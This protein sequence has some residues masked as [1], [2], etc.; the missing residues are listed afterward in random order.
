MIIVHEQT[1]DNVG[2]VR[3]LQCGPF[4]QTPSSHGGGTFFI[5]F[6]L[7]I[8]AYTHTF[9]SRCCFES[10]TRT[11]TGGF[12]HDR[13]PAKGLQDKSKHLLNFTGG[14]RLA[15]SFNA[16]VAVTAVPHVLVIDRLMYNL[17]GAENKHNIRSPAWG[18]SR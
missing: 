11:P 16:V 1:S 7:N 9:H 13:T 17:S 12:K 8:R 10:H 5:P 6:F 15:A 14:L 2:Q 3:R 18:V 4:D